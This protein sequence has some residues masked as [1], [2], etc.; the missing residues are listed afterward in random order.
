MAAC[1]YHE[2][3]PPPKRTNSAPSPLCTRALLRR[4]A[5]RGIP[6]AKPPTGDLRWRPPVPYG[7]WSPATLD[8]TRFGPPCLQ[9]RDGGWATVEGVANASEDCLFLNVVAPRPPA[10]GTARGTHPVIVYFH[11]GE[12]HYGA[13]SDKESDW[14]F[15]A[16]DTV[17]VSAASR[18]GPF[19]YLASESLRARSPTNGT[20]SYGMLDQ[21][22]VLQWVREHIGAFGGNASNVALMGESSGVKPPTGPIVPPRQHRSHRPAPCTTPSDQASRPV[23]GFA[24]HLGRLPLWC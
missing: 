17:L 9:S 3:T 10:N 14:P 2:H 11:A 18:L 21:R 16:P 23:V 1:A 20:G 6:F 7:P 19:G 5:F 8:A 13:A 24:G 4:V 15:F 12:F 22:L